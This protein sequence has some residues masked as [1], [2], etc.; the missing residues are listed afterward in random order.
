L[1]PLPG[2]CSQGGCVDFSRK[3]TSW[4]AKLSVYLV[5]FILQIL[6]NLL[7]SAFQLLGLGLDLRKLDFERVV[8]NVSL[9]LLQLYSIQGWW[10]DND[11]GL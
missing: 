6:T 1:T 10:L 4:G 3:R 2:F 7:Q 5:V 8:V 9:R 11:V